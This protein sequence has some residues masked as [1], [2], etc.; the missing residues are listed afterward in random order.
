MKLSDDRS[1][2]AVEPTSRGIAFVAFERGVVLDWGERIRASEG[3]EVRVV[4]SLLD[5]CAADLLIVEEAE[6]E[7]S[8]RHPRVRLLLREFVKHVRLRGIPVI[9]VAR[10]DLRAAW[11]ARG[12]LN[13]QAVAHAIAERFP[14]LSG[15]LPPMRRRG[16]N[17]DPRVKI[18][19]AAALVLHYDE[20]RQLAR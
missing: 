15:V 16:A 7:G 14:E 13:K 5:G 20:L 11:A 18:F 12:V 6:A 9:E 1:I 17:A 3:D 19:D 2:L 4:D 10:A 8:K